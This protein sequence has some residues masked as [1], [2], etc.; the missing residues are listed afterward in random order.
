MINPRLCALSAMILAGA[1]M[2]L[3]PHPP[4]FTPIGA[5]ALFGGAYFASKRLA[6][7]IPLL[8]MF[9]SDLYISAGYHALMPVVYS[10]FALTVGIGFWLR[11]KRTALRT[12]A[13][14]LGVSILFFVVTNFAVWAAFDLYPKTGGGLVACYVAAIPYFGYTLA[15]NLMFT[16]IMFGSFALAEK[17]IP[18]IRPATGFVPMPA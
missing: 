13:A 2:R 7:A 5:M 3:I 4:N 18:A 17:K 6:L 16:A 14:V 15:G 9:L 11:R 8:A 12:G 10:C 1:A